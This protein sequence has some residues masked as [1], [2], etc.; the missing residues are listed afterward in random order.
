MHVPDR[1]I[2]THWHRENRKVAALRKKRAMIRSWKVD[3]VKHTNKK[4]DVKNS[5]DDE[6]KIV[7]I[8]ANRHATRASGQVRSFGKPTL[9]YGGD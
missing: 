4:Q 3:S 8:Y 1:N 2:V 7:G 9:E 5:G 6:R